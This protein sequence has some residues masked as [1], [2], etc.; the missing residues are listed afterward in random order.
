MSLRREQFFDDVRR[1]VR[2]EQQPKVTTDADFLSDERIARALRAAALWLT[3]KVVENYAPDDFADWPDHSRDR[4]FS[5]V[6]GFGAAAAEV[7]P[8]EAPTREQFTRA[9][10]GFR[11]LTEAVRDVVLFEW[12]GAVETLVRGIETWVSGS[13]W[14]ARRVDRAM[15]ELLL[16]SYTLPQLQI[17][18]DADLYVFEPVGRF[19]RGGTGAYDIS[20]QPSFQSAT[21]F[22]DLENHWFVRLEPAPG[23]EARPE[24]WT[25][26]TFE[27]CLSRLRS[28][29]LVEELRPLA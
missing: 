5:A 18:A 4:L 16:E 14:R 8:N 24:P 6:A 11:A 20:I 9:R 19:V 23:A 25:Q 13:G 12:T 15:S 1:A 3:P 17:F 28:L 21:L 27:A 2:L 29:V 7:A 10:D 22:R 26:A